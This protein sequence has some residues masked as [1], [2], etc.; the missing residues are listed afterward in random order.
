[1]SREPVPGDAGENDWQ[2]DQYACRPG[3]PDVGTEDEDQD[4]DHELAAGHAKQA[5]DGA[6]AQA[7]DDRRRRAPGGVVIQY[8]PPGVRDN[9]FQRKQ[10]GCSK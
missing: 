3:R 2:A 6:H 1:M 4:R 9:G 7:R 5:A 8:R 10:R